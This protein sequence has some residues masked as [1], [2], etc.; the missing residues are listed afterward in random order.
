MRRAVTAVFAVVCIAVISYVVWKEQGSE[1]KL[2]SGELVFPGLLD[3]LNGITA[4]GIETAKQRIR[5]VKEADRWIV[6]DMHGYAASVGMVRRALIGLAQIR[7][8]ETAT[9][10]AARF[11]A[12]GVA[13]IDQGNSNAVRYSAAKDADVLADLILGSSRESAASA[14]MSEYYVRIPDQGQAWIAQ[15]NLPKFEGVSDWLDRRIVE[16]EPARFM[17]TSIHAAGSGL[18]RVVRESPQGR[19][20]R[21]DRVPQ[22]KRVRHQFRINDIGTVLNRLFFEEVVPAQ[23]WEIGVKFESRTNDGLIIRGALSADPMQYATFQA[24]H[25]ENSVEAVRLQAATLT[26][27]WQGWAYRLSDTRL[28]TLNLAF[29][30]LVEDA[31]DV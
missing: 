31:G 23:D 5:V 21:L 20:F 9:D 26:Q 14:S 27:R 29:D 7:K 24:S 4:I 8:I 19:D 10:D 3:E 18:I 6:E 28:K 12:L 25:D 16:F 2:E 11:A 17:E 30:D 22:G 15:G 1:A 13:D